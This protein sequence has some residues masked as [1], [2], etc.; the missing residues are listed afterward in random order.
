MSASMMQRVDEQA[1][2]AVIGEHGCV[3]DVII[4]P[5]KSWALGDQKDLVGVY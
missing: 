4:C 1:K 5:N 3:R 2:R